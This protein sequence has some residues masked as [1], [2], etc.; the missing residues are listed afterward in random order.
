[1]GAVNTKNKYLLLAEFSVRTVNYGPSFFFFFFSFD[2]RQKIKF[3]LAHENNSTQQTV[4]QKGKQIHHIEKIYL[5][6]TKSAVR[7]SSLM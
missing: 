1:M 2:R 5:V 7:F 6:R 4:S 3:L